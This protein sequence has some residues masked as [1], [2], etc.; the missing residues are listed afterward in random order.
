MPRCVKIRRPK[1]EV[2]IGDLRDKVVIQTRAITA[3]IAN[4]VD[5]GETFSGDQTVWAMIKTKNG[6]QVFD[7]TNIV[8][9]ATHEIYIRF[10]TGVTFQSWLTFK[11]KKYDILD[12]Q[13]LEERDE[14]Y[15]LRCSL[16]GTEAD[17][18]NFSR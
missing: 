3:P 9:V 10:I 16:R 4:S 1:R 13:N 15:L 14:F 17:P 8:G 11:S 2:C 7:G 18:I 12:V 6:V 5:L